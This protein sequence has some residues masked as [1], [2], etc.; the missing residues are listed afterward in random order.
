MENKTRKVVILGLLAAICYIGTWIHIPVYIGGTKSMVHMG[1]TAIFLAATLVGK[2]AFWAGGIGCALFDLFSPGFQ[3]W[4]IPTFIIKGLTGYV[5]G[6]VVF[7][8]NSQGKSIKYNTIGF[9]L[10]G[11]VSLVGYFIFNSLFF[12]GWRGALLSLTTSIITTAIGVVIAIPISVI[13]KK[14]L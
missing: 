5:A 10:G 7:T 11:I 14:K 9:I 13:I 6:K 1:T 12:T 8:N 3:A 2:D 4:T